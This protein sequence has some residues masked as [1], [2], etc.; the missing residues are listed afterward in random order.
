MRGGGLRSGQLRAREL[1]LG[2]LEP[3][4]REVVLL[5]ER[6]LRVLEVRELLLSAAD[7]G[8]GGSRRRRGRRDEGEDADAED[9]GCDQPGARVRS[10][11]EAL[12][13]L[14]RGHDSV[15]NLC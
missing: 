10:Q 1:R 5:V 3:I 9:R 13:P 6:R 4:R 7:L 2:L 8:A 15:P 11:K 12:L 14:A